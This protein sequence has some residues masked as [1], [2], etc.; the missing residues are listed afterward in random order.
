MPKLIRISGEELIKVLQ[1]EGF[2]LLRQKSSHVRLSKESNGDTCFV[3]IPL[4]SEIDRG[5][6]KNILRSVEN[7]LTSGFIKDNFYK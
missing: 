7:Y 6:L 4:H 3:T 2:V 5:T 1:K